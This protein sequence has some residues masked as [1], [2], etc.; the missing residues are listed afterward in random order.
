MNSQDENLTTPQKSKSVLT[1]ISPIRSSAKAV[2]PFK[3]A[4]EQE[5]NLRGPCL[6]TS[7]KSKPN[8]KPAPDADLE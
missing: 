8:V 2:Q 1:E 4:D 6:R 3:P 7:D 5:H